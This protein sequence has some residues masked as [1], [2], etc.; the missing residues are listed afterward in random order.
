MWPTGHFL[1]SY[2]KSIPP[3]GITYGTTTGS[4]HASSSE[5]AKE[6]ND[7]AHEQYDEDSDDAAQEAYDQDMGDAAQEPYDQHDKDGTGYSD[8]SHDD[9]GA[10]ARTESTLGTQPTHGTPTVHPRYS[11]WQFARSKKASLSSSTQD[12]VKC[13]LELGSWRIERG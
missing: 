5:H 3:I 8:R 13:T 6:D 1:V 7:T 10:Q 2:N 11:H 12:I 4:D 9:A